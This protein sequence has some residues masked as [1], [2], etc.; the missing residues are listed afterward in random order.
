MC[1]RAVDSCTLVPP[2]HLWFPHSPS[3]SPS[4]L[5][6]PRVRPSVWQ[7]FKLGKGRQAY[8]VD[9][10]GPVERETWEAV[11]IRPQGEGR[12]FQESAS[13]C[14]PV[15]WQF[16]WLFLWRRPSESCYQ[17][18]SGLSDT[19]TRTATA[20]IDIS[21]KWIELFASLLNVRKYQ[22]LLLSLPFSLTVAFIPHHCALICSRPPRRIEHFGLCISIK[23][24]FSVCGG[25]SMQWG[26]CF[27]PHWEHYSCTNTE[28]HSVC[29]I[30]VAEWTEVQSDLSLSLS[31][32]WFELSFPGGLLQR[33][34]W[35]A[36]FLGKEKSK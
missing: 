16:G 13:V 2:L 3:A 1:E 11:L 19:Q 5:L 18:L 25:V 6:C 35:N 22:S 10:Q 24:C 17:L 26:K 8:W 21:A 15:L 20:S 29:S 9:T 12:I 23:C 4:A 30:C 32:G 36:F 33:G 7:Q 28:H 27:L 34:Q 14:L 31:F